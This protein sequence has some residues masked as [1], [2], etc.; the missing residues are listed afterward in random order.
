MEEKRLAFDIVMAPDMPH[1]VRSD[2]TKLRQ[3][4]INLLENAL[5][6]TA[7]GSVQVQVERTAATR[8]GEDCRF[9]FTV[10]DTGY[11]IAAGELNSLFGAFV[12]TEAGRQAREGTGLGLAISRSFVRL[13]GGD[14]HVESRPGEGT[15]FR[16]DIGVGAHS[17]VTAPATPGGRRRHVV[18]LAP[19]QPSWRHLVVDDHA[20]SRQ[21]LA[22][23]LSLAG[24]QV[25]Q[26][27]DGQQAV[28]M[29]RSWRPHLIWMNM[30]M[31]VM[32]GREATRRI[33]ESES[34]GDVIIIA[35]SASCLGA[36]P[37]RSTADGCNDFMLKP[38]QEAE[39]FTMLQKHLPVQF[40]FADEPEPTPPV[41]RN[42]TP[43]QLAALPPALVAPLEAALAALE[44][45]AVE[46]A[47]AAIEAFDADTA[48]GL[49]A[50]VD[51]Y[52]Y[53]RVQ[54]LIHTAQGGHPD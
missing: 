52:Q 12:Q 54:E 50:L 17:G 38:F 41:V 28:D 32:G 23:Q 42:L 49:A 44:V 16:F 31:P 14:M 47:L 18:G 30:R 40:M 4:L 48:R 19:G 51:D 39:L 53:D 13:M 1:Q 29:A 34:G 3:V 20:P 37:A 2:P 25:E 11:G 8:H 46:R 10:T 7:T 24:F 15:A 5:K 22:R 26:A 45:Q 35:L 21:L 33:R 43:A 9:L 36:D 6:F 27:G